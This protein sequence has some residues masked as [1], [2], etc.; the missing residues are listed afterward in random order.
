[1]QTD[2]QRQSLYLMTFTHGSRQGV[3]ITSPSVN[4]HP[5][6][7]LSNNRILQISGP[8]QLFTK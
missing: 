8:V 2:S 5:R 3:L 6:E 1:M 7:P 4:R